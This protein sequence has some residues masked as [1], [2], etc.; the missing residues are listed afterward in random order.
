[1]GKVAWGKVGD[2]GDCLRWQGLLCVY[3]IVIRWFMLY[4]TGSGSMYCT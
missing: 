4:L 3:H 2:R 1:M